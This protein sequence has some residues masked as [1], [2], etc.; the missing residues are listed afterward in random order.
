MLSVK[1]DPNRTISGGQTPFSAQILFSSFSLYFFCFLFL[2][3]LFFFVSLSFF[4]FVSKHTM[5]LMSA[6]RGVSEARDGSVRNDM[7]NKG[8]WN[9]CQDWAQG[10]FFYVAH[11]EDTRDERL[12]DPK[13][14]T[15]N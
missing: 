10:C 3:S 9:V 6:Q 4:P 5:Q 15:L 7:G 14:E 11:A 8:G 2:F 13:P 1:S 12:F